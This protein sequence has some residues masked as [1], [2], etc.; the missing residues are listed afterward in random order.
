MA[1]KS[2]WWSVTAFN[3]EIDLLEGNEYPSFVLKVYGGREC[4]PETKRIHFQGAV[5]CR[6]QQRFSAMKKW[7]PKAHWEVAKNKDALQKYVMKAETAVG[8][9][10]E[11]SNNV[12]LIT[13]EKIMIALAN[14]WRHEEYRDYLDADEDKLDFKEAE[15]HAYWLAVNR[16]LSGSPEF[17]KTCQSFARADTLTLWINTRKTWITLKDTDG[18]SITP[19]VQEA[20]SELIS[21]SIVQPNGYEEEVC[22]E[23]QPDSS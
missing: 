17:R 16:L 10:V 11:R 19:S 21:N 23:T 13:M 20:S 15:K 1:D 3:D 4:C 8:D 2:T 7:L 9:K 5:Q 14:E 12:Q 18:Y 6:S 22:T